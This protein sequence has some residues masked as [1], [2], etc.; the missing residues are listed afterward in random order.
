[1]VTRKY[2]KLL[3]ILLMLGAQLA[4][5]QH[6][7]VHFTDH[8]HIETHHDHSDHGGT[9]KAGELCQICVFAKSFANT[10]IPDGVLIPAALMDSSYHVPPA[11]NHITR[12]A[13]HGY[14]A[15]GPPSF[16]I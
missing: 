9:P 11:Q 16:L 1:M 3:L 10:A 2:I 8:G 15:R 6:A 13:S 7:T 5:A 12:Q 4:L 14:L